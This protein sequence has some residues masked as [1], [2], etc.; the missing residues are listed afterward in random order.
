MSALVIADAGGTSTSWAIVSENGETARV[1]TGGFNAIHDTPS[2][3][4]ACV[5]GSM[6]SQ[7]RGTAPKIMF[8]GAGCRGTE[9]LERVRAG[10]E[11]ALG[12]LT[13]IGAYSD[14]LGAARALCGRSRGIACI[15]GTGSN[16]CLCE[17]GEI[18]ANTPSLGYILGDEGGGASI[19]RQFLGL[20][21]KGHMP[22]PVAED[23]R[24]EFPTT[25]ADDVIRKVYREPGAN[26]YLASFMPFIATHSHIGEIHSLVT[27]EFR[28]FVRI[29]LMPYS[30]LEG[31]P[32]HFAGS[33]A[34]HFATML[35]EALEAEG[36][37]LGR[38]T[39]SPLD[40]LISF[41]TA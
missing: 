16:S 29:N 20:L 8:Y 27:E 30:P 14:M 40:G 11:D 6:L 36:L 41:H 22:G 5:S 31:Q 19:G 15:L 23:F 10:L 32:I 2:K 35:R 12:E 3:L 26:S 25:D 37:T 13:D 24:L 1:R 17:G 4:S 18:A 28:R 21:F 33:V 34:C 9:A 39:A 38:V 7:L